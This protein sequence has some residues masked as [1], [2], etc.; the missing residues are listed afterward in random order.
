MVE[1]ILHRN[2]GLG[3]VLPLFLIQVR[4][5]LVSVYKLVEYAQMYVQLRQRTYPL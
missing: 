4:A 2:S 3:V 1:Y 5:A